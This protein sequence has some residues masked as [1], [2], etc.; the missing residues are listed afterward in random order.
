ML[1]ISDKAPAGAVKIPEIPPLG[2][3]DAVVWNCGVPVVSVAVT[4][5]RPMKLAVAHSSKSE[6][7]RIRHRRNAG[8]LHPLI[9]P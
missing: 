9:L 1:D 6:P 4:T 5:W 8:C 2:V 3:V 7:S